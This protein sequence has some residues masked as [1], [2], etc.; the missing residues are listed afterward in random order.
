MEGAGG[1]GGGSHLLAVAQLILQDGVVRLSWDGPVQSQ[2]ALRGV[3]LP[4]HRHQR[5]HCTHGRGIISITWNSGLFVPPPRL[6][7]RL[8]VVA[9]GDVDGL[10][11]GVLA[12][13]ARHA[14]ERLDGEGVGGLRQHAP[15]LHPAPLQ[16][17]LR[18]PVAD[19]V[20]AGGARPPGRPAHG[21]L[22]GVAQV[23]PAA[24]VQRFVPRQAERG[25]VDLGDD[26]AR[27]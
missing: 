8:T 25:V 6:S 22:D 18:W 1:G 7:P 17:A 3:A 24:A 20:P 12:A 19:A 10:A 27:S 15:H 13:E 16:A 14:V 23:R 5:G 11:G 26:A 21:A 2:T 4:D 9:R